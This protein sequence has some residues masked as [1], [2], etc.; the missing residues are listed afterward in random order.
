MSIDECYNQTVATGN[1]RGQN[2]SW[3]RLHYSIV[4]RLIYG[5][6]AVRAPIYGVSLVWLRY[7]APCCQIYADCHSAALFRVLD[8][9]QRHRCG[10][11][12]LTLRTATRLAS[13]TPPHGNGLRHLKGGA[14]A[15]AR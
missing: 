5:S 6:T 12:P 8:C 1:Q 14:R 9:A 11:P 3:M 10:S 4:P 13:S 7:R 15:I 2:I